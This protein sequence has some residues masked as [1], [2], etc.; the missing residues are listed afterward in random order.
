MKSY[1]FKTNISCGGCITSVTPY[2]NEL[3]D[4]E[5]TVD[6]DDKRKV[7]EVKT[8]SLTQKEIIDKVHEAGYEAQPLKSGIL[9]GLFK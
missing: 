4:A 9:G 2:L 5:W 1:K 8:E 6:T 7:L 3:K